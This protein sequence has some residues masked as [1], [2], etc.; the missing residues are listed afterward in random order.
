MSLHPSVNAEF[1]C[2]QELGLI[3]PLA[4]P[5]VPRC[6]ATKW[7]G[8]PMDLADLVRAARAGDSRLVQPLT[9]LVR[10]PHRIPVVLAVAIAFLVLLFPTGKLHAAESPAWRWAHSLEMGVRKDAH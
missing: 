2:Q 5:A 6:N 7:T 8:A 1:T 4:K 3:R 10:S 9:L